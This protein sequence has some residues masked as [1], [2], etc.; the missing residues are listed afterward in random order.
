MR[1]TIS[2]STR[3]PASSFSVQRAQPS[4]GDEQARATSFAS[5]APSSRFGRRFTCSLR[6]RAASSPSRTQ[7]LRK[8]STVAVPMPSPCAMSAS[9]SRA[10][11][12]QPASGP[13]P[14]ADARQPRC[15][16]Q[17]PSDPG[18]PAPKGSRGRASCPESW[19]YALLLSLRR[20]PA[21]MPVVRTC[22]WGCGCL[23]VRHL[24]VWISALSG[25]QRT[26]TRKYYPQNH[27]YNAGGLLARCDRRSRLGTAQAAP[28]EEKEE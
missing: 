28:S 9:T 20:R 10:P 3:R 2:I 23:P 13:V 22:A 1:S 27:Q 21:G 17:S 19:P 24:P 25:F 16:R 15:R 8:R 7:R 14:G 4:G 6:L 5:I 18:A 12:R 11:P 26:P